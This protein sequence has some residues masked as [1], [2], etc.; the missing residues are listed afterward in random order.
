MYVRQAALPVIKL[1]QMNVTIEEGITYFEGTEIVELSDGRTTLDAA[2]EFLE[3]CV[4]APMHETEIHNII[5]EE[6]SGFFDG[7]KSAR[8]TAEVIQKRVQLLLAEAH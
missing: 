7:T 4:A 5:Y 2:E 3:S 8:E 6:L 1:T